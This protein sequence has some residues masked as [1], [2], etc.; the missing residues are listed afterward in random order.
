MSG[1]DV[2]EVI[3]DEVLQLEAQIR[4]LQEK[5]DWLRALKRR[6]ATPTNGTVPTTV[7]IGKNAGVR[8]AATA[9]SKVAHKRPAAGVAKTP[10]LEGPSVN[11]LIVAY[12]K[13]RKPAAVPRKDIVDYVMAHK[14]STSGNARQ[15]MFGYISGLVGRSILANSGPGEVVLGTKAWNPKGREQG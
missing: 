15:M 12:V 10:P 8:P 13:E 5:R 3:D 6:A 7:K 2:F 4:A 9:T 1:N 11:D 14:T